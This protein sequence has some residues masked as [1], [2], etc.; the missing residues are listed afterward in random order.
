MKMKWL[1]E[2]VSTFPDLT[3]VLWYKY[4]LSSNVPK[5]NIC[6]HLSEVVYSLQLQPLLPGTA[7]FVIKIKYAWA[8]TVIGCIVNRLNSP[9]LADWLSRVR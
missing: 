4:P 7:L 5:A 3:S 2:Y 1:L 9:Q 6:K 8:N